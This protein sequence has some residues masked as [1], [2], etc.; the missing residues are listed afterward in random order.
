MKQ[1]DPKPPAPQQPEEEEELDD[2][3]NP[4]PKKHPPG[5]VETDLSKLKCWG[6]I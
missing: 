1:T 5:Y 6:K 4:K 2:D 3:G